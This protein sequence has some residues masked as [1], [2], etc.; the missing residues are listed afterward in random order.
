LD[1]IRLGYAA[2]GGGTAPVWTAYEA[3]IFRRLDIELEPVLIP[4][5]QAVSRALDE[6]EIQLANFA[7]PAAIQ[8]NLEQIRPGRHPR[9]HE[10]AS[11]VAYGAAGNTHP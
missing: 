6:G 11:A 3:G 10:P 9:R 5:S 1:K 4:G 7:A 2:K 8:R